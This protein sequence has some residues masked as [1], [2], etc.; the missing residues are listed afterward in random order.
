LRRAERLVL[1]ALLLGLAVVPAPAQAASC[2]FEDPVCQSMPPISLPLPSAPTPSPAPQPTSAPV[3]DLGTPQQ[4]LE[5]VAQW[6]AGGAHWMLCQVGGLLGLPGTQAPQG[7]DCPSSV[8]QPETSGDWFSPLYQKMVDIG[9]LLMLPMLLLALLQ[10]LLKRELGMALRAVF[11]YVPLAVVLTAISVGLTQALIAVSEAFTNYVLSGYQTR[12]DVAFGLV[13][14][15]LGAAAGGTAAAAGLAGGLGAAVAVGA[16]VLML[17][18]LL[19]YLELI[20]RQALLY[21][22]VLFLPLAFACMVWPHLIGWA[23]RLAALLVAVIF[24]KFLVVSVLVLGAAA[25]TSAGGPFNSGTPD[26]GGA[27]LA[28]VLLILVAGLS[29]F[30]L[31]WLLPQAEVAVIGSMRQAVR[32]PAASGHWLG[33]PLLGRLRSSRPPT[34]PAG[35]DGGSGSPPAGGGPEP[36]VPAASPRRPGT[37]S[38]ANRSRPEGWFC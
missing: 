19:V 32:L 7:A 33:H 15:G 14:G 3:P 2:P 38:G 37:G 25:M 34:P 23:K 17:S 1:G 11:G 5:A 35:R 8:S 20:L 31:L 21:A 28:G 29:P 27:V 16:M 12:L 4:N 13:A 30:G 9:G 22:I 18:A 26:P 36:P 24:A 10:A 6:M